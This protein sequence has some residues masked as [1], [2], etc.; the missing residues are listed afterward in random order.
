MC[1]LHSVFSIVKLAI[2]ILYNECTLPR[3]LQTPGLLSML[4]LLSLLSDWLWPLFPRKTPRCRGI[5]PHFLTV[6]NSLHTD[7]AVFIL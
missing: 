4:G 5:S 2:K 3:I 1:T 6:F 7:T